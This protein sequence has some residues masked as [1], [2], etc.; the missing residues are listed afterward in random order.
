MKILFDIS[1]PAHVHFFKNMVWQLTE[2]GHDTL[3]VARDKEVTLALLD[4]YGLEHITV[5]S[6]AH[7]S[8]FGQLL[9]LIRRDWAIWTRSLHFRPDVIVTRN[10]CGVQAARLLRAVGIFDTDDGRASGGIHVRVSLPFAQIVTTPDCFTEDFGPKH[11]K[12]QGYKQSAYLHPDVYTPNPQIYQ[13]LGLQEGEPYFIVRFVA[14]AASHDTGEQ[15]L[16][17]E[18]KSEIIRRLQPHG[19]VF[20]SSEGPLQDEFAPLGVTLE[21][22]LIHDAL[23][24]ATLCVGDSQTMAAEAAFLGT[25]ALRLNSYAGRVSYLQELEHKYGLCWNFQP[26][27]KESFFARLDDLLA[28]DD[29][30]AD[31]APHRARMLADKINIARWYVDFIKKVAAEG[32]KARLDL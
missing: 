15:G 7:R 14:M 27:D 11:V 22:H 24:Y 12:Y 19:R 6:S 17:F 30:K 20:I 16:D 31:L 5:G 3:I 10:P 32:P 28:R 18:T 8:R 2:E 26:S 25:P 1:H 21:P 29:A 13:H 23:A 4:H 9:E